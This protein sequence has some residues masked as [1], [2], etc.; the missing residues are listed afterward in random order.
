MADGAALAIALKA[1]KTAENAV[2][3]GIVD[4]SSYAKKS[5]LSAATS[6]LTEDIEN[7]EGIANSAAAS[8]SSAQTAAGAAQEA[9]DAAQTAA[10]AAKSAAN[11]NAGEIN[12][13][14]VEIEKVK[15]NFNAYAA[16]LQDGT[17]EGAWMKFAEFTFP[18]KANYETTDA[19][20]SIR[21]RVLTAAA[22]RGRLL[23]RLRYA[24]GTASFMVSQLLWETKMGIDFSKF[25]MCLNAERGEVELYVNCSAAYSGYI[26]K[27][28][29][30]GT[31]QNP[32]DFD[33][34]TLYSPTS[35][36]AELPSE[37][38]GWAIIYSAD[39]EAV[40]A[41]E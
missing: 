41:S 23:V 32:V 9:A 20:F 1:L 3:G 31:N 18:L 22:E 7:A 28:E 12:G 33:A 29:E 16:P 30:M 17:V 25:A 36:T 15:S 14:K 40:A 27:P 24:K 21:N 6:K 19:L 37:S 39:G 2:G 38:D 5:E 4:L 11:S 13:L 8:A 35:G 26:I 10:N 34:W